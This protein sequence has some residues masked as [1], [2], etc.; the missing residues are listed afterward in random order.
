MPDWYGDVAFIYGQTMHE[1]KDDPIGQKGLLKMECQKFQEYLY[2][3]LDRELDEA[4][5]LE[6]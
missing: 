1:K 2:A 6:M 4:I 5:S 3:Y